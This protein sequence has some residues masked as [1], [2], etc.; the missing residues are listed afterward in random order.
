MRTAHI[1]K[2]LQEDTAYQ[3]F[4]K[5]AMDKFG[6]KS[7]GELDGEKKKEFFNYIDKN[8][9]GKGEVQEAV[10]FPQHGLDTADMKSAKKALANW[11]NNMNTAVQPDQLDIL[12]DLID[13]YADAYAES[14]IQD[15]E[16][17]RNI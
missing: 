12:S 4:F 17:E 16:D 10:Y 9:K 3:E 13:D 7:I 14:R 15:L 5:K 11:F 8:Y 2:K 6:I 1:I